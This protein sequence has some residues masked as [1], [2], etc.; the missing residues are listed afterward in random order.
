MKNLNQVVNSGEGSS[1]RLRPVA[2]GRSA[3]GL[4]GGGHYIQQM[5]GRERI[6][7]RTTTDVTLAPSGVD[8]A[9]FFFQPWLS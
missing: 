2:T 4:T 7:P 6:N 3:G 9:V 8:V 1:G 5:E